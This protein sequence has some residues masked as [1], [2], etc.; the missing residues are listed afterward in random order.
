M[1]FRDSNL[2]LPAIKKKKRLIEEGCGGLN[3]E[4]RSMINTCIQRIY[5]LRDELNKNGY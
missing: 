1:A 5:V 2:D 4:N 3:D